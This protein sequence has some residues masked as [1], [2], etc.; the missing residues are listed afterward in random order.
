LDEELQP[1][2]EEAKKG[3]RQ[4]LFVDASHFVHSP[5]LGNLWSKKRVFIRS[6]SGRNRHNVLGA[7]NAVSHELISVK[8]D[9]YINS[10]TVMELIKEIRS[11]YRGQK[12]TLVMDN[13]RYQRCKA[14]MEYAQKYGIELL[15]LPSYSPNLNL[16]ER[17]WKFVKKIALNN[18]YYGDFI[19]FKEGIEYC[20]GNLGTKFKKA[21]ESLMTLKFQIIH[22]VTL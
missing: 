16:I 12:I 15:F 21:V 11:R 3:K 9:A 13:A 6:P 4:V 7:F 19:S 18:K 17:L 2:L 14:V 8:N 10:I 20:L 22:N 1:R 5:F